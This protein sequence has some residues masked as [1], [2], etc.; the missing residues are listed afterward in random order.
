LSFDV[1]QGSTAGSF[2]IRKPPDR[3]TLE[4]LGTLI[5]YKEASLLVQVE[6]PVAHSPNNGLETV[7]WIVVRSIT[8]RLDHRPSKQLARKMFKNKAF[9][10]ET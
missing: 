4:E 8:C 9:R 10:E 5:T 3:W 1:R 2:G 6:R 7:F